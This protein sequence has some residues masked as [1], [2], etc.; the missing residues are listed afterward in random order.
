[1]DRWNRIKGPEVNSCD[2]G[3]LVCDK[4]GKNIQWRRD[5]LFNKWCWEDQTGKR[6]KLELFS[7]TVYKNK[8]KMDQ[9]SKY[10]TRY[11]KIPRGKHGQNTL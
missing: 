11:Y 1:M 8:F 3:K 4:G 10:V 6:M 7:N 2:S 9:N 5:S